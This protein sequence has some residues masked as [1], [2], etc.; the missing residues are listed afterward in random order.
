MRSRRQVAFDDTG[1]MA[2]VHARMRKPPTPPKR[3]RKCT[4]GDDE[5]DRVCSGYR[6]F[7]L[8]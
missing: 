3:Q 5:G 6:F 4:F 7:R 8:E 2:A 1:L